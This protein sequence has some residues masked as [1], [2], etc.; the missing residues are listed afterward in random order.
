VQFKRSK[1]GEP[2]TKLEW[3]ILARVFGRC[4]C[5]QEKLSALL[6]DPGNTSKRFSQWLK[7]WSLASRIMLN[8]FITAE[9]LLSHQPPGFSDRYDRPIACLVDGSIVTMDT[10]RTV[11]LQLRATWNNK[12]KTNAAL[13]IVWAS[14]CG[15]LLVLTSLFCGRISE[16]GLVWL[17]HQ[18]LSDFP[19]GFG[20]L[21]DKGTCI[22]CFKDGGTVLRVCMCAYVCVLCSS[23]R[24]R[25]SPHSHNPRVCT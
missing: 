3:C 21:V 9:L 15:L 14:A 8:R 7:R 18:L 1:P 24:V 10:A 6:G 11:S 20:R 23:I 16:E 17:H 2:L 25:T 19:E 13:G 5:S 22:R 4:G 12:G